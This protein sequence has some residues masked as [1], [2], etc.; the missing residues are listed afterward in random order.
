MRKGFVPSFYKASLETGGWLPALNQTSALPPQTRRAGGLFDADA[1]CPDSRDAKT[2]GEHHQSGGVQSGLGVPNV[3]NPIVVSV[4][5]RLHST[6]SKEVLMR[7]LV[8]LAGTLAIAAGPTASAQTRCSTFGGVTTCTNADGTSS[9]S[10]TFGGVTTTQRSD[11]TSARS[12]TY[13]GVTT[14]QDSSGASARSNT[15]GGVTTTQRSDGVT[16]RSSTYG[17]VT[18]ITGSDGSTLRCTTYA[19]VRTCN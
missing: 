7:T 10:S 13:G 12:S 2:S 18:T 3:V 1:V 15:Y 16:Y 6:I 4:G 9:R 8:I 17:G 5:D 19:G 11:G 14:N